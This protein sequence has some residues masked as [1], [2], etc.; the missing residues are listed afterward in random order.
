MAGCNMKWEKRKEARKPRKMNIRVYIKKI[1]MEVEKTKIK[2]RLVQE[3]ESAGL[4]NGLCNKGEDNQRMTP[5]FPVSAAEQMV[6]VH[7]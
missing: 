6:T 2:Q 1:A 5:R 4:G 3:K 7:Q